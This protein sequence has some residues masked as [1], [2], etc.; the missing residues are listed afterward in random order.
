MKL[1]QLIKLYKLRIAGV[2][3]DDKEALEKTLTEDEKKFYFALMYCFLTKR[4]MKE[5]IRNS[6]V[7]TACVCL[8]CGTCNSQEMIDYFSNY[9]DLLEVPVQ[10]SKI[11]GELKRI[12]R[13]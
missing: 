2:N 10:I 6:S 3:L 13:D 4:D 7:I 8:M 5:I 1:E 12:E 9:T 11:Y